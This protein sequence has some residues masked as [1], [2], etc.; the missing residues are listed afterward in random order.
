[1]TVRERFARWIDAQDEGDNVPRFRRVFCAI[2]VFYDALDA[3]WGLTERG[4]IWLPHPRDP[5]L[6]LLQVSLVWSGAM[7]VVGRRIWMFGMVAFAA[8]LSEG[9][10]YFRLNDFYMVSVVYLFLA[11]SDGG[12][13]ASGQRPRWVRDALLVQFGWIYLATGVLKLNPDWLGGGHLFVRT[14]YLALLGWPYPKWL[15]LAFRS[16]VLDGLLAK[17]A[18]ALEISLAAVLFARRPY[19]LA[20]LLALAIHGFGTLMTNVWFFSASM[21][22]AVWL[23]M[24]RPGSR[25]MLT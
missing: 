22:A 20:V 6:L 11:H 19:W 12:P 7:L 24:P 10:L 13:S 17:V 5:G 18:A 8:R 2:W 25:A 14:Q 4:R 23:L 16:L 21:I 15:V 3:M 9:L 1:L